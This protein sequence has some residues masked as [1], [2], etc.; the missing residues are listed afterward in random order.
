MFRVNKFEN[1]CSFTLCPILF[2]KEKTNQKRT[3]NE[4]KANQKRTKN[5]PKTNQ[6]RTKKRTNYKHHNTLCKTFTLAKD[7]NQ[8][9]FLKRSAK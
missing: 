4:S 6:K 8:N 1:I 7:I 2:L 9:D 3:E 5:E